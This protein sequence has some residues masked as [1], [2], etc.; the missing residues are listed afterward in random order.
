MEKRKRNENNF[1]IDMNERTTR[2]L[3]AAMLFIAFMAV[4]DNWHMWWLAF[5][6]IGPLLGSHGCGCAANSVDGEKRKRK[7]D[8]VDFV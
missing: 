1:S 4:F 6:F 2:I 8:D 5:F 7:N 3:M